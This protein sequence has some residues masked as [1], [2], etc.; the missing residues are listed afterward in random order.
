M[1]SSFFFKMQTGLFVKWPNIFQSAAAP[2]IFFN[3]IWISKV[4]VNASDG[5]LTN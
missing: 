3:Y 1:Q 5:F 4:P 2:V